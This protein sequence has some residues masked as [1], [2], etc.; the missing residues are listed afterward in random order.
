MFCFFVPETCG[1]SAPRP[2]IKPEPLALEGEVLTTGLPGDCLIFK[3]FLFHASPL[4]LSFII[5]QTTWP[6]RFQFPSQGLK[7]TPW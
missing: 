7:P 5:D 2:E 4:I 1:I 6:T 3:S